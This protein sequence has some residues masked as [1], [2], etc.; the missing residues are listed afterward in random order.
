MSALYLPVAPPDWIVV[1]FIAMRLGQHGE[2]LDVYMDHEGRIHEPEPANPSLHCRFSATSHTQAAPMFG[3]MFVSVDQLIETI[4]AYLNC[5]KFEVLA[6]CAENYTTF[7]DKI[8]EEISWDSRL[9]CTPSA[10]E[11]DWHFLGYEVTDTWLSGMEGGLQ[12]RDYQP[13]MDSSQIHWTKDDLLADQACA[14]CAATYLNESDNCSEF[15]VVALYSVDT[16]DIS[17]MIE[18]TEFI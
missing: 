8:S 17:P 9:P 7:W 4:P 12:C 14:E 10:P 11:A 13:G 3:N 16:F 6:V 5:E 2:R 1:G 15:L 18:D